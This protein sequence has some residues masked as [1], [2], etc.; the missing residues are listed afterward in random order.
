ME[1]IRPYV[2]EIVEDPDEGKALRASRGLRL[3]NRALCYNHDAETSTT[4]SWFPEP[5]VE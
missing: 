5:F 1:E 4:F 3:M 2:G